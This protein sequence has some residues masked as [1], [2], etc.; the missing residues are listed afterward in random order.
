[1][2][3]RTVNVKAQADLRFS[4]IVWDLDVCCPRGHRSSHN[5][6]S[7]VYIQ[8][9]KNFSRPKKPNPRIQSQPYYM[10]IWQSCL[11]KMTGR[12]R[13][14]DSGVKGGNTLG[15]R[16]SRLR[17]PAL[18][19]SMSQKK[20]KRGVI[21]VRSRISTTIKKATLPATAPSQKTSVSLNNLRA[22]D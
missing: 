17:P 5:T 18:A 2:V 6:S 11:R 8:G 20:R 21:L 14:R 16:K 12:I 15:S 13:R 1:M 7:K 9:S 22:G 3:Q 4:T 19:P 10:I